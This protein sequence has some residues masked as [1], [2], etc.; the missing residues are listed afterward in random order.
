MAA[1]QHMLF[2]PRQQALSMVLR[3]PQLLAYS[4]A[5]LQQHMAALKAAL[6]SSIDVVLLIVSRHPNLL[7]FAPATLEAKLRHLA[8][9][10]VLPRALAVEL[11]LRTPVLLTLSQ[12][13][14]S[15]TFAGLQVRGHGGTG[16]GMH[17]PVNW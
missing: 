4:S 15:D 9:L 16:P 5:T 11:V 6:R 8:T 3:Q 14:L 1:L 2:V 17:A 13:R 12:E 7:C 10:L